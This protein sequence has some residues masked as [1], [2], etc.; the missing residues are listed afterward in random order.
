MQLHYSIYPEKT[1]ITALESPP[2]LIIPGLFGSGVNWRSF[3]NILSED[4]VVITIDQ[5]NHGRSPHKSSNTYFDLVND[6]LEFL[7]H[8]QIEKIIPCGHSMGGKTAML[9]SLLHPEYVER[10][11]ILD[12]APVSYK[13]SHAPFLKA[14]LEIDLV[15]LSSRKEADRALQAVIPEMATRL[16]LL[17]SLTGS[18]GRYKWRLNLPVLYEFMPHISGFP[19]DQIAVK[20]SCIRTLLIR[21]SDSDYVLPEHSAMIDELFGETKIT[22]ILGAGHWI[23]A[24]KPKDVLN[25]LKLFLEK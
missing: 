17:Q 5:R 23:H 12:I 7:K 3:A 24:D 4:Y 13:H 18:P 1:D 14:L 15:N 20:P 8:H 9:F 6:L 22:T 19:L 21:G 16:F 2:V 10:L 11:V 25:A